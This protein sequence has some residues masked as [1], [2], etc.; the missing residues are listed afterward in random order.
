MA[1]HNLTI[2]LAQ[3][4]LLLECTC[5][6]NWRTTKRD[7]YPGTENHMD[8]QCPNF[9]LAYNSIINSAL[10]LAWA[11]SR[12]RPEHLPLRIEL[13]SYGAIATCGGKDCDAKWTVYQGVDQ[14]I[15]IQSNTSARYCYNQNFMLN[16]LFIDI[17]Y[18]AST[19]IPR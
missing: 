19:T 6:V 2:T 18:L 12:Y 13:D 5:G 8:W 17:L 11:C 16:Q 1:G 10:M 7:H 15:T 3:D 4:E 9:L 14:R